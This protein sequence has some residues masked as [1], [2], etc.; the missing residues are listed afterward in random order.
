MT[1][2]EG[3]HPLCMIWAKEAI[4][5]KSTVLFNKIDPKVLYS[6]TRPKRVQ[7]FIDIEKFLFIWSQNEPIF[8][9]EP[10]EIAIVHSA[11][12]IGK[13]GIAHALPLQLSHPIKKG[14]SSWEFHT[15]FSHPETLHDI[16]IFIDWLP[17]AVC[18]KP[19]QLLF[20]ES[21]DL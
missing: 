8:E 7:E 1:K 16:A 20:P 2:R 14:P 11:L 9:Q 12:P 17:S 21:E 13:D 3:F 15:T 6:A 4:F 10:P 5:T 19:V 18:P